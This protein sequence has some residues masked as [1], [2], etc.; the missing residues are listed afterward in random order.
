MSL[1]FKPKIPESLRA[2]APK[3]KSKGPRAPHMER[4]PVS[5]RELHI[6]LDLRSLGVSY[7]DCAQILGRSQSTC[8]SIIVNGDLYGHVSKRRK[9]LIDQALNGVLVA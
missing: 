4:R 7:K 2:I 6:L 9:T 5:E 1:I 3:D 8:V